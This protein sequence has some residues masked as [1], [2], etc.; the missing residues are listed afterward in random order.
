VR[1]QDAAAAAQPGWQHQIGQPDEPRVV[2][3]ERGLGLLDVDDR[4]GGGGGCGALGD[5]L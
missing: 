1:G 5:I 2:L 4:A 3:D